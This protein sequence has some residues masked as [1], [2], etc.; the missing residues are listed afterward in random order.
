MKTRSLIAFS[1]LAIAAGSAMASGAIF[2][3]PA[4]PAYDGPPVRTAPPTG[5][6]L[7]RSTVEKSVLVARRTGQLEPAG[8]AGDT[9]L[10]FSV[11]THSDLTRAEVRRETLQAR[12]DGQLVPAGEDVGGVNGLGYT[13]TASAK[14]ASFAN[15]FRRNTSASN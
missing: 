9:P 4:G 8:E 3:T 13:R 12:A 11:P 6:Q 2:S 10:A 14:G 1:T 7:A 15:L 5:P